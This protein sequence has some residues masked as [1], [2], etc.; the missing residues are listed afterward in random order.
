MPGDR[1]VV[2][3]AF[4]TLQETGQWIGSW[5]PWY[6]FVN[7][8]KGSAIRLPAG[9][10]V[11]AE[12]HYRG[13]KERVTD[14][15]ELGLSFAA[16]PPPHTVSD[17]V[18]EAKGPVPAGMAAQ[19]LR[20]VTRLTAQTY[21]LALWP[22]ITPGITS[23]EVSARKPDGET[24]VMLFAKDFPM[25]WPTPYVYKEPVA[26]PGGTDLSVVAYFANLGPAPQMGRL[27]LT[28]RVYRKAASEGTTPRQAAGQSRTSDSTRTAH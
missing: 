28:V 10:H 12:I 9:S 13:I 14:Q 7:F 23:I 20:A 16:E 24:E 5:T 3:A 8:P 11:V 27:R 18:L 22:E 19:R 25:D 1:R 4:F 26:L 21:A 6:G 17:V 2:R 15:G